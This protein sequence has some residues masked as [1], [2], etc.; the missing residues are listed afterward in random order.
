MS[1]SE[2][3]DALVADRCTS[4][5]EELEESGLALLAKCPGCSDGWLVCRHPRR[6]VPVVVA[7]PADGIAVAGSSYDVRMAENLSR[8]ASRLEKWG[9]R[10]LCR[11]FLQRIDQML[12]ISKI[13]KLYWTDVFV[14]VM[15]DVAES[16][17]IT[18]HILVPKL[19]WTEACK[20]FTSH[21]QL[22]DYSVGLRRE[23][24]TCKQGKT[25]SVQQ[26]ANR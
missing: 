4:Y 12:S 13:D 14:H 15:P 21:F 25:D 5:R 9:P 18:D 7:P 17:W 19:D 11:V 16:Q 8:V 3:D 2:H 23:Y 24:R 22:S 26:Y 10:S 6:P 20:T 1:D